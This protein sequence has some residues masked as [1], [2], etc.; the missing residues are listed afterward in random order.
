MRKPRGKRS[1]GRFQSARIVRGLAA[2]MGT[3]SSFIF[4]DAIVGGRSIKVVTWPDSAYETAVAAMQRQGIKAK[5]VK[6]NDLYGIQ[7]RI[8]TREVAGEKS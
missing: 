8:H 5:I 2:V 6:V 3:H 1:F 4:N 7:T